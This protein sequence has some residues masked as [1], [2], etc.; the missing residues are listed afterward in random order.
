MKEYHDRGITERKAKK[1]KVGEL[2][3]LYGPKQSK[4]STIGTGPFRIRRIKG[5]NSYE[6]ET[7]GGTIHTRNAH[8]TRLETY[9]DRG[10]N[11]CPYR[12]IGRNTDYSQTLE[13]SK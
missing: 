11:E 10:G 4:L 6:L 12:I 2:V 3:L 5:K 1:F 9:K 13:N 8:G 7:L